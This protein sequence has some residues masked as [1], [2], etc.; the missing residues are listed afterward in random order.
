MRMARL[1]FH[2][3]KSG[4]KEEF[5]PVEPG[6]VRMY[7]C[8]PTVYDRAH[9]GNARS[10]VVF[11]VLYR[12]L[13]LTHGDGVT[14]VRNITDVDDK[15]NARALEVRNS[16][17]RRPLTEIVRAIADETIEWYRT[18]T[19]ALSVLTPDHEPRATEFIP[20]MVELISRLLDSG[21]A[22]AADGHVLFSVDAFKDY[23]ELSRRA[24]EDMVAGARVEVAPYKRN[25]IDFVLWK[26]SDEDEPG[27]NSPWGRG[28]PG[29][30][31][32]CSAMSLKLLGASFD[33]H[34]GGADLIFPHHENEVA[35]STCANPGS[36]FARY[37]M[38]NGLLMVNGR[39]MSKSLGNFITIK[40]LRDRG[41]DGGPIRLTL[42]STHYRHPLDWTDRRLEESMRTIERWTDMVADVPE[43]LGEVL[44]E[45]VD[46]LS[47]DLNT[48]GAIAVL[49]RLARDGKASQLK[50]SA[51]LLGLMESGKSGDRKQMDG[52]VKDLIE[53]LL[54]ERASAR[55]NRRF[56]EA[57]SIRDLLVSAGVE[58]KDGP[59][60]TE[61][62]PTAR[63]SP[64]RLGPEFLRVSK[65]D[66]GSADGD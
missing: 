26:P 61:W 21:Y 13:R 41:I 66:G 24:P 50:A 3:T 11:D 18:D 2:N 36:E 64:D 31:I 39:K 19:G 56:A 20:E 16:G 51:R 25:P 62:N 1:R 33:I 48:P 14:Y 10:V 43:G 6:R 45:I 40:D 54:E 47:D 35:Q 17:D 59:H 58:I 34:A 49:H 42:L 23:G 57:D 60:G 55:G 5:R 52:N 65:S 27:W 44:P 15:I 46:A 8:G 32:E 12:L 22:Y 53:R 7:V 29:W 38:H 37:W 9:L 63:F 30:H 28:R 4:R